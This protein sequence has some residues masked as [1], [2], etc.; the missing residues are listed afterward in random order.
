MT[1]LADDLDRRAVTDSRGVGWAYDFD[2]QTRWGFYPAGRPNAVVTSF[3]IHALFDAAALPGAD[4][5]FGMLA[6]AAGRGALDAFLVT[7]PGG[8]VSSSTTRALAPRSTTRTCWWQARWPAAPRPGGWAATRSGD[9]VAFTVSHQRPDGSWPYG[10]GRGLEWVDGYHTAYVLV[11]LARCLAAA[12]DLRIEA[13]VDRGLRVLH[14]PA[15]RAVGRAP[16]NGRSAV[17]DRYPRSLLGNLGSRNAS[18]SLPGRTPPRGA[19][20]GL[21]TRAHAARRRTLRVPAPRPGTAS[22]SPTFAGATL[23]C[24]LHSR[25]SPTLGGKMQTGQ[26]H[27]R[28]SGR[29]AWKCSAARSTRSTYP[30]P[31]HGATRS[32]N[33]VDSANSSR[34]TRPR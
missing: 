7:T 27:R 6:E 34:S 18:T 33:R 1:R 28:P 4:P 21:D 2:V 19:C 12:E 16:R 9:A 24:C 11:S 31:S 17:S 26:S 20:A 3:A 32:S 13:A 23:T 25:H 22:Q 30:Q 10:E 15:V 8:R 5:R 29:I 14:R